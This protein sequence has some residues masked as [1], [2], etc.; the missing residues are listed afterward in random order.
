M[1]LTG[2]LDGVQQR[3]FGRGLFVVRSCRAGEH[4]RVLNKGQTR[5]ADEPRPLLFLRD[6]HG[7][8]IF[9]RLWR[10]LQTTHTARTCTGTVK[11]TRTR[12]R[13]RTRTHTHTG[14]GVLPPRAASVLS[15]MQRE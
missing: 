1:Q 5:A 10:I 2:F 8:V 4:K 3:L 6:F 13:T 12:T 7:L 9:R 15:C 14:A 11:G